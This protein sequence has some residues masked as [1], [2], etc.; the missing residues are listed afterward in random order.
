M[1]AVP[2]VELSRRAIKI[3]EVIHLYI[4]AGGEEANFLR[5]AIWGGCA[6]LLHKFDDERV[7][8]CEGETCAVVSVEVFALLNVYVVKDG[9]MTVSG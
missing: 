2:R 6:S 4:I 7:W 5:L 8:F 1:G 3:F 9:L